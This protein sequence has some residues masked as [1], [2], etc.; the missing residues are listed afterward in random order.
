MRTPLAVALLLVALTHHHQAA[1]QQPPTPLEYIGKSVRGAPLSRAVKAGKLLFV[2]GT[3]G[4]DKTGKIAAGDF[5][6][7][8]NQVMESITATLKASGAGWDRV[9]KVNVMLVRASDFGEMNR[10]YS[11]YFPDGN[12]PART[13]VVVSALPSPDFLLEIECAAL[14]E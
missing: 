13:T 1:A 10:I 14:L 4:F 3:P 12:Y 5:T 2:S 8:M 9:A 6:A 11:G 7:Q